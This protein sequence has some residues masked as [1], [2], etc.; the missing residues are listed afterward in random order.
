[1][2]KYTDNYYWF[3]KRLYSY[4]KDYNKFANITSN[5]IEELTLII[6]NYKR[7]NRNNNDSL[8]TAYIKVLNYLLENEHIKFFLTF[9]EKIFILIGIID[10][11]L[12]I[13]KEYFTASPYKSSDDKKTTERQI[14]KKFGF[15]EP[16]L[17]KYESEIY[18]SLKTPTEFLSHVKID[19][20]NE[21]LK[22]AFLVRSFDDLTDEEVSEI[23]NKA[24][25]FVAETE[26]TNKET[27][28]FNAFY[29][30]NILNINSVKERIAFFIT[31]FDP[32]L[33]ILR[34]YEEESKIDK[35]KERIIEEIGFYH[36]ELIRLE[37]IYHKRFCPD[38]KVSIWSL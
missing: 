13:F 32:D 14:R 12:N 26:D 28:S 1:M 20:T 15:F 4:D 11:E 6:N 16:Y 19:L 36:S 22:P 30:N 24:M 3:S 21:L 35:S 38:K 37:Q 17:I 29:S 18:R 8:F 31:V 33:N 10:P 25:L 27:I 7:I 9:D 2:E 5:K 23:K 34:I